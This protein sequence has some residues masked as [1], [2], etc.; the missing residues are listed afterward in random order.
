MGD[1]A[2]PE[3]TINR[4]AG[5]IRLTPVY[6]GRMGQYT[7]AGNITEAYSSERGYKVSEHEPDLGIP[8]RIEFKVDSGDDGCLVEVKEFD[9]ATA[10]MRDARRKGSWSRAEI[11]K[12]IR[13]HRASR[14]QDRRALRPYVPRELTRGGASLT[15]VLVHVPSQWRAVASI[16]SACGST[17][18][19]LASRR[20]PNPALI[21]HPLGC[22]PPRAA[23]ATRA[24]VSQGPSHFRPMLVWPI[25]EAF[26]AA[27]VQVGA[28]SCGWGAARSQVHSSNLD[29]RRSRVVVQAVAP[30]QRR[31]C[32]WS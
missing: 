24:R 13:G 23:T 10:P 26:S 31:C 30:R 19:T 29:N 32:D 20:K 11:L 27:I 2:R 28:L 25:S 22:G 5:R 12:P 21:R 17:M 3:P 14:E 1:A 8:V 7:D 4:L 6:S 9:P 15:S 16:A 18:D